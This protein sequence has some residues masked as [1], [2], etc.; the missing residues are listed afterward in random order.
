[1]RVLCFRNQVLVG[2]GPAV[3]RCAW[4]RHRICLSVRISSWK[5]ISSSSRNQPLSDHVSSVGSEVT[6]PSAT[7]L[8]KLV[9][10]RL[11]LALFERSAVGDRSVLLG[12]R[13][14]SCAC[15][16]CSSVVEAVPVVVVETSEEEDLSRSGHSN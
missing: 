15:G 14:S 5:D 6:C 9:R 12:L 8:V 2:F 16:N 10:R 3:G 1:M 7:R 13:C 4:R 11:A